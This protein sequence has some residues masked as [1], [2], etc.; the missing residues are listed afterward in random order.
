M[1][2]RDIHTLEYSFSTLLQDLEEYERPAVGT[3]EPPCNSIG[4]Q[5]L[6]KSE[7][8]KTMPSASELVVMTESE[9]RHIEDFYVISPFGNVHFLEPVDIRGLNLD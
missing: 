8:Y 9:L 6:P 4:E 3:P 5:K 2:Q 1:E 7:K